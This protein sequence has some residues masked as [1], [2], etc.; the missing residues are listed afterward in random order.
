MNVEI[1]IAGIKVPK[2]DWDATPPSIQALVLVLSERLKHQSERLSQLEEQLR[3]N[4]QNS[5]KPPSTD[6]FGQAVVEQKRGKKPKQRRRSENPS[7]QVRKL[8]AREDCDRVHEVIPSVC[9]S[10]GGVLQGCDSHPHRHQVMELPP[11]KPMV[12]EY[13]LHQLSC[14]GC[15]QL[16]RAKLPIGVSASGY[17]ERLSAMVS[18]L[19]GPYRHSY[20]RVCSL[21]EDLFNV[22]LSRGSVG[23]LRD[24]IS[25]SVSAAVAE[26]KT[27][28]QT[29][30]VVHSDETSLPQGNRDGSNP[31]G[32]K[33]WLWVLVTPWVSFFEVVL[34]RSQ[35]SAKALIGESF[36]GIVNS[37]RHSAY[38]WIPLAQ[39]QVCWAHLKR[40]LTAIAQ[41]TGVSQ[42]VGEGLLRRERRLFRWWH[43]VRDGTLSREQFIRQVEYLRRGFK[44]ILEETAALPIAADEKTPLAKT[45]RTFRR[46]LK[47]ESALWTFVY[48]P[49]VEPTNN[50]AERALRPAVIWRKTSFGTQSQSGSL[51]VSRMLTVAH[52][53][54]AQGRNILDFLTQA[55][56]AARMGKEP[57]S[58]IP[59]PISTDISLSV[60]DSLV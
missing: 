3:K 36:R 6:K 14:D 29:Q 7:R 13:R 40:D 50:A 5:S 26:A 32:R 57:P 28:V 47:V 60:D 42:E 46:L 25:E 55:C 11:I 39:W 30:P 31:K 9:E 4:S 20:R 16:T 1:E 22:R 56:L 58:L 49:G 53:L 37:D 34:S 51:F 2:A 24:E 15:G 35:K 12:I 38:G 44:S 18:M 21:M 19:S 17:G 43:C 10:C 23:R 33:G 52:S 27:Y 8:Q 45:V 54:K 48:T 41:R 59:H